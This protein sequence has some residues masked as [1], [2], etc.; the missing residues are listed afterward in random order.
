MLTGLAG[1][2][3]L[4][5]AMALVGLMAISGMLGGLLT[6]E[7]GTR[8]FVRSPASCRR[9]RLSWFADYE[10]LCPLLRCQTQGSWE[11]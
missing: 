9:S 7:A 1:R 6:Q 4:L 5:D 11:M 8:R 2:S 3:E 10:R